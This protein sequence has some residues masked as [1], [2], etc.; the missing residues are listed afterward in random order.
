MQV[1]DGWEFSS[2]E[3]YDCY[4]SWPV[5]I[6]DIFDSLFSATCLQS[7]EWLKMA[8]LHAIQMNPQIPILHVY[9]E[10]LK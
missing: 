9:S 8:S 4:T 7:A 3:E 2:T 6:L 1:K 10:C 5:Y